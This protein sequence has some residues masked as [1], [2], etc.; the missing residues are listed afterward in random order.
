MSD[1][2]VD[3]FDDDEDRLNRLGWRGQERREKTTVATEVAAKRSDDPIE[4]VLEL[5]KDKSNDDVVEVGDILVALFV[6][7]AKESDIQRGIE[8]A[9]ERGWLTNEQQ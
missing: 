3:T 1:K 2:T 5:I 8:L 9:K 6:G 7:N 4:R